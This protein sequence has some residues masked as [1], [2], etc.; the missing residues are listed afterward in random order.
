M[1]KHLLLITY[2][3]YPPEAELE[4][5]V[6]TLERADSYEI[7]ETAWLV[8]TE[9]S[10]R[11]WYSNLERFLFEDDELSVFQID[12]HDFVSDPG[13]EQDLKDWLRARGLL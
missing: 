11:W 9:D 7:D 13:L 8:Y 3:I 2:T 6:R 10:A 5:I 4:D 12:V 1:E